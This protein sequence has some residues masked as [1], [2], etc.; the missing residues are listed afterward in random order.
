MDWSLL[1]ARS[2]PGRRV[3]VIDDDRD[4]A[5]SLRTLLRLEGYEVEAANDVAGAIGA[6]DRFKAEVALIDVRLG[7]QDGLGL[8][9]EIRKHCEDV[10]CVVMTAYASAET[11]IDALHKGAY[12][13]LCKPFYPEDL[14][15]TLER[16]FER[17]AL[18]RSREAAERALSMRN[19]ELE[20]INARLQRTVSA[21]Q[22]LSPLTVIPSLYATAVESLADVMGARNAALYLA[23]GAELALHHA[24]RDGVPSRI[25]CPGDVLGFQRMGGV[26]GQVSAAGGCAIVDLLP[27]PGSCAAF[28]LTGESGGVVG[29]LLVQ[30]QRDQAFSDQDRELGT[31]LISFISE[32]VRMLQAHDRARCSE[33]RLR[34]IIDNSP[35]VIA[36]NDLQGRY[37]VVNRQFETWHGLSAAD[38]V[39]RRPD[40]LLPTCTAQIYPSRAAPSLSE[41]ILEDETEL[42][43][44]DGSVRT[45]LVTRFPIRDAHG[46]STGFG[47]IATDVTESRRAERR[48][49]HSQQLEALGQLAGGIAHDFNNL[50]TVIIGNLD[51]LREKLGDRDTNHELIDDSLSSA[52]SGRDLVQ[53]LLAFGRRRTPEPESMDANSIV[54][55][56][57][58]VLD[59]TLGA[60]IKIRWCLGQ[61]LWSIAVDR[62]QFETGL[63]NLVLN[64]RD[65][66]PCGGLLNVE[67][68]NVVVQHPFGERETIAPG[69]YVA[70]TVTDDGAG[71]TP[72]VAAQAL[73][74]FFSTKA[75]GSG[76]GLGLSMVD[77][78][79]RQS[80]GHLV[81]DSKP[82]I[83]TSVTLYIPMAKD[84]AARTKRLSGTE[85]H[86]QARDQ[87]ILVVEDQ[88]MVRK[89]VR[90]VLTSLGYAVLEAENADEALA[91]LQQEPSAHLLLTDIV[92]AGHL[93]GFDLA[94]KATRRRPELRVVFMSGC[95]EAVRY[96]EDDVSRL[97]ISKPFTKDALASKVR[98]ALAEGS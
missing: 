75:P 69:C 76:S 88:R 10:I 20:A 60:A 62:S 41:T 84:G 82:G 19:Q 92:L 91:V 37:Q 21:M 31:I 64:A 26:D 29:L 11:A 89:M 23:E 50:L 98:Q 67:T 54:L 24:L 5:D 79:V 28:P 80:G 45:V 51:L 58:R 43:L 39:G 61:E 59:R 44:Q 52:S 78:F 66:M 68:K 13:F 95:A 49:R 3:L 25:A 46:R 18:V 53:S 81:I 73:R 87:R 40:E 17:L 16:C 2:T 77:G 27:P 63:L 47:T 1:S 57:S 70:L 65:A 12:D 35:S 4:F 83:G 55:G 48:L 72:A 71:M 14:L 38:V 97:L 74:P 36:L 33:T 86:L 30:P 93:S 8:I 32:Q 7:N 96:R 94:R 56:L 90:S 9:S 34:E 6:L 22:A 85:I 42:A 15:A